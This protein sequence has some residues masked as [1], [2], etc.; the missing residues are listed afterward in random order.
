MAQ[1]T[2]IE[3][4]DSTLNLMMGCQG[5]ELWSKTARRCYAGKLTSKYAGQNG[6]PP[7]FEQPTVFPQRIAELSKWSDLTGQS[8]P[9][10][11]WLDGLPRIV[12]LNDM[13]DPFTAPLGSSWFA[14]FLPKIA[15]SPHICIL[16]TKRA[17]E[18]WHFSER[19]Q[20]PENLWVGVS[21][22]DERTAA[23]AQDLKRV[24]APTKIISYEPALGPVS[25]FADDIQCDGLIAGGESGNQ[26]TAA[27][28]QEWFAVARDFCQQ[29]GISFF[30]KQWGEF[31]DD[32]RKQGK[33]KA[34]R[35]LDGMEHTDLPR[36]TLAAPEQKALFA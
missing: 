33:H 29:R 36:P 32:G 1:K 31:G 12:F 10:K 9:E 19:H 13:G 27:P 24:I 2:A 26:A 15:E 4:C 25:W 35:A 28:K 17:K 14:P 7:A 16:L 8:R 5:C 6:W 30:F 18:L 23:R 3:W 11:P 34:G 22:T 20:I 21:I